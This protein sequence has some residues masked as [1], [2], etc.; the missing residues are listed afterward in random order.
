MSIRKILVPTD[1]SSQAENAVQAA[2]ILA[3]KAKAE[4][5][6]LHVIE[7]SNSQ[8]INSSGGPSNEASFT[9]AVIMHEAL[10]AARLGLER[11][12][13]LHDLNKE[14]EIKTTQLIRVGSPHDQVLKCI[15]K[16]KVDLVI[17]GTK[18]AWGYS[19]VLV[20]SNTEKI[21]RKAQCPVLSVKSVI[22]EN[23]F[24]SIVYA[25]EMNDR[26]SKVMESISAIQ[27]LFNSHIHLVWINTRRHFQPDTI[28]K[29]R[30][31]EFAEQQRMVNYQI[32]VYNDLIPEEGIRNFAQEMDAG[33]I[34]MGS[35]THTGLSRLLQGSVSSDMVNHAQRPVLTVSLKL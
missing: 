18:G 6:L 2:I 19:E 22:P 33:M 30:L 17:M 11:S 14:T 15:E 29:K 4:I 32:H 7:L 21:V 9:D 34:I 13:V 26:E 12:F 8:T 10:E 28:S 31:L 27:E 5:I 1:F 35:S 23:A 24:E 25:T 3:K 16:S 20:G